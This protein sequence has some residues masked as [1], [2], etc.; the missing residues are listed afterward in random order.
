MLQHVIRLQHECGAL[1]TCPFYWGHGSLVACQHMHP[2]GVC[3]TWLQLQAKRKHWTLRHLWSTAEN[4]S[5]SSSDDVASACSVF[6]QLSLCVSI[7]WKQPEQLCT[8][9]THRQHSFTVSRYY[10]RV[11][12][13]Q[14]TAMMMN[15]VVISLQRCSSGGDQCKPPESHRVITHTP[16]HRG[17]ENPNDTSFI[18]ALCVQRLWEKCVFLKQWFTGQVFRCA[19]I[20]FPGCISSLSPAQAHIFR[21][22]VTHRQHL[23]TQ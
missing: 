12:S 14:R 6:C 22:Q 9:P 8:A 4:L 16:T 13:I 18:I 7:M 10:S 20:Q 1:C 11:Q 15:A 23:H 5:P 19:N 3:V 17:E 2:L 21:L